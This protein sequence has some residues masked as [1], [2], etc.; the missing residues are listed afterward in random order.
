MNKEVSGQ[1][2]GIVYKVDRSIID[3]LRNNFGVDAIAEIEESLRKF[4]EIN[5]PQSESK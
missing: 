3:R 5:K 1:V 4:D 2:N